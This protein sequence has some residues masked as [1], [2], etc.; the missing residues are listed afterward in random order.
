MSP[1]VMKIMI[2]SKNLKLLKKEK[3]KEIIQKEAPRRKVNAL[4][5]KIR[6]NSRARRTKGK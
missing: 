4:H 3:E 1:P 2:L 6:I 5:F